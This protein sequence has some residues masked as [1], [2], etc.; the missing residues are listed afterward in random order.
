DEVAVREI[1][2]DGWLVI[3]PPPGSFVW[4]D[5]ADLGRP[6]GRKEVQVASEQTAFRAG[7]PGARMPGAALGTLPRGSKVGLADVPPR[8]LGRPA[9]TW[10]AV[11]PPAGAVRYIRA[12]GVEWRQTAEAPE[13]P[14]EARAAF[15]GE[16]PLPRVPAGLAAEISRLEMAHR[17]ILR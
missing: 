2:R 15:F 11:A 5:Q 12:E 7:H 17:A 14:K 3:E 8:K 1:G 9:K 13:P 10:R 6:P 16:P 4:V